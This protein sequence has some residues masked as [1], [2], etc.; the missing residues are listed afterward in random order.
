VDALVTD[1]GEHMRERLKE[2]PPYKFMEALR[3][4]KL[5]ELPGPLLSAT[6]QARLDAYER[7]ARA[8]HPEAFP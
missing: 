1:Q 6:G 8:L 5:V 4:G 2:V 7:L 3:K